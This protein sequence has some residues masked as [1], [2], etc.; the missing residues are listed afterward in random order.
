MLSNRFQAT[1][2]AA[3]S[4]EPSDVVND[5]DAPEAPRSVPDR[6]PSAA[7]FGRRKRLAP[8]VGGRKLAGVFLE[9]PLPKM[10]ANPPPEMRYGA[11]REF[12]GAQDV[13]GL[14]NCR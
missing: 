4:D 12:H 6:N 10:L 1:R 8:G 5:S 2:C 13:R 9:T 3:L 7:S 11:A 14:V